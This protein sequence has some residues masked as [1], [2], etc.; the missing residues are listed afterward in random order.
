MAGRVARSSTSR[1]WRR[2]SVGPTQYV[3]YAASKAAIDTFTVG[4]AREVADEGIRVNAIRP[5]V[6]E[7][8]LHASGGLPDR[9]R[10]LAP[11]IPM[12][13][14]DRPRRWRMRSS[15]FFLLRLPI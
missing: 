13:R 15:I 6:I 5:G 1:R 3:D 11:S 8:D 7:T 12:Q 10:E 14:P 4:L 2:S 9:P